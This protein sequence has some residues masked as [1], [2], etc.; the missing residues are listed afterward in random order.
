M[1]DTTT[2]ETD[3]LELANDPGLLAIAGRLDGV[4]V[5]LRSK[6]VGQDDRLIQF[7][8][9][10]E[11]CGGIWCPNEHA[12]A[13]GGLAKDAAALLD[14]LRSLLQQNHDLRAD[15]GELSYEVVRVRGDQRASIE[16]YF[17]T[18][19]LALAEVARQ[20]RSDVNLP[21]YPITYEIVAV[22]RRVVQTV[23]AGG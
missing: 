15:E 20:Q 14:A 9:G 19:G 7:Y 16:G 5:E 8:V 2:T 18:M 4:R 10:K 22:R 11:F 13:I 3:I 6:D 23:T 12:E 17:P 21:R 1:S